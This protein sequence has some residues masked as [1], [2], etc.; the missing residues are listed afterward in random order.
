MF[1]NLGV[2][3]IEPKAGV[4][5]YVGSLPMVLATMV[6]ATDADVMGGRAHKNPHDGKLYA[7]KFPRFASREA[8][9]AFAAEQGVVAR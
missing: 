9:V 1:G 8:A 6:P 3:V 4:F 5:S 2:H 7:P